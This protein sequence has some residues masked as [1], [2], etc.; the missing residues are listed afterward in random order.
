MPEAIRVSTADFKANVRPFVVQA[1]QGQQVIVTNHGRDYFRVIPCEP[2]AAPPVAEVG[3]DPKL[4]EGLDTNEPGFT[5][6]NE[7]TH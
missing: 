2:S 4:Y 6:W 3:I 5:D 1:L 7:S